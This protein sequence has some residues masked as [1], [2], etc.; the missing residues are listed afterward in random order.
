MGTCG[1][2]LHTWGHVRHEASKDKRKQ[3]QTMTRDQLWIL[4]CKWGRG[5][6]AWVP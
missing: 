6:T 5:R 2:I 1:T 3:A 4:L